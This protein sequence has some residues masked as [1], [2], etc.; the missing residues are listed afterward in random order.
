MLAV[1]ALMEGR[2]RAEVA[3]LFKVSV[4]AVD[5]WW[6]RWQTG[7]RDAL[8]SRTR[9][10]RVG[11]HQVLSEAEQAAVRQAVL[12]HTPSGL[13]LSGQLWTRSLIGELIF[14]LYRIRFTEPGVGKYLKRWGLMFQRPDKRAIEQ[15]P[16]AVRVWHEESW[17]A[18]RAQA[19]A[20]R[21]EVLFAD[22][23]GIRSDQV[24]GRT[25]GAR[26]STPVVRRT[27]NRFLVK[28]MS[29]IS[30]K[31]RMHFMVFTESFDSKTVRAWL[32]DH[33]DQVEL[34]FLPSYSPELNPD[35]LVNADLER[36]LPH[37][38]R[39][40]NQAELASETR[41]FFHRRQ[42]QPHIVRGYFGGR[43]VRY[44]LDE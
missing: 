2:D 23:V 28:A 22:Q 3:A 7:G 19:K 12:D 35:E 34:H 37:T 25:W 9:G 33:K 13:G 24:T 43:H 32:A 27:G 40:R 21:G 29:A 42:R 31:G 5:N 8:L 44:I 18:I 30:T 26:G 17:P 20:E 36:S 1:S 39:A 41:R 6:T 4:R 16:E 15:D 38:H 11:E 14:K 10:R